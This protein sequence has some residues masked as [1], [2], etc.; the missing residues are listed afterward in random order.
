MNKK[1]KILLIVALLAISIVGI[2]YFLKGNKFSIGATP[3]GSEPFT[4][5]IT[6]EK[7]INECNDIYSVEYEQ[8]LIDVY[9][10][11]SVYETTAL[12]KIRGENVTFVN[13]NSGSKTTIGK[14]C[15]ENNIM[16]GIISG[17][18]VECIG[19]I[20]NGI[21]SS[22]YS[23]EQLAIWEFWNTWVQNSGAN[24]NGFEKGMGN[25]NVNEDEL[26]GESERKKAQILATQNNYNVNIYFLKYFTKNNGNDEATVD[27]QPNLIL[28]EVLDEDEE[29]IEIEKD[30][31][32]NSD[33]Y[34][35]MSNNIEDEEIVKVGDEIIYVIEFYNEGEEE[36]QNL[37][38]YNKIP[39]NV[40]FEK[41]IQVVDENEIELKEGTDYTYDKKSRKININVDKI[42]GSKN[43]TTT[44]E[45]TE[46]KTE[47][48]QC[49]GVK[50]KLVLKATEL[51]E[52][53]YSREIVNVAEVQKDNKVLARV[54]KINTISDVYLNVEAEKLPEKIEEDNQCTIELK[55]TNKGL[56]DSEN[57]NVK[58]NVPDEITIQK[59]TIITHSKDGEESRSEG[60]TNNNFENDTIRIVAQ[61]TTYIQLIGDA[62][63]IE[64]IKQIVIEGTVNDEKVTWNTNIQKKG[65]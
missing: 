11:A 55:I 29:I 8:E 49:D 34:M 44:N 7:L 6:T 35:M 1:K 54:K 31:V 40:T 16:A 64:E 60:T 3:D 53:M 37:V 50:Y 58:I 19:Y 46:E 62:N 21:E 65:G 27:N 10:T 33:I 59:Y 13:Y 18:G 32:E 51:K 38:F 17:A 42:D 24:E 43:V 14:K 47:Y 41:L 56:I 63:E 25:K 52:N 57:V 4:V 5:D 22:H 26:N 12:A 45:E 30:V 48:I 23:G 28:V 2:Y 15:I 39:K 20:H 9:E 61:T 36:K